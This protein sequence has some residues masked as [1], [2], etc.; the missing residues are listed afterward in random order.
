M[1]ALGTVDFIC[2]EFCV[3]FTMLLN[4][5]EKVTLHRSAWNTVVIRSKISHIVWVSYIP[6]CCMTDYSTWHVLLLC[7][8]WRWCS[9]IR[10]AVNMSWTRSDLIRPA[11]HSNDQRRRWTLPAAVRCW[12]LWRHWTHR[13]MLMWKITLHL[14]RL[15]STVKTWIN[16][17][18]SRAQIRVKL[19]YNILLGS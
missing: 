5:A 9:L 15:L 12:C 1:A 11:R 2:S 10:T 16:K 19:R 18:M 13:A 14:S 17:H 3:T 4:T 6:T 8:R 7:Y